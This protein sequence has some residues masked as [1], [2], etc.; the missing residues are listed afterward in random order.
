MNV[1][2]TKLPESRVSLKIELTPEEVDAALERTYKSLVQRVNVPGFRKGK[3]PRAMLER[4]VGRE[5]FLAEA[6]EEAVRWGYRKALSEEKLSPIDQPDVDLHDHDSED[7]EHHHVEPGQSFRFEATVS[8]RP[9][10][11]LPD[12]HSLRVEREQEPVTDD[13]IDGVLEELRRRNATLEPTV[14]AA[15]IGD[16]VTMNLTARIEGEEVL[17]RDTFD[18]ELRDEEE[19]GPDPVFPGLSAEL[20]GANRGEIKEIALALPD[21]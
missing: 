9:E 17:N 3:A 4:M 15:E 18:Y 8:V 6:T 5:F 7:H 16:V 11:K 13:D 12:Y 1:D 2:V 14:R 21:E 19:A 20:A 10:V